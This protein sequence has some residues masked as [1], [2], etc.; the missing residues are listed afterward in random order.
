MTS[1]LKKSFLAFAHR[2]FF[3]RMSDE[4][5]LKLKYWA[6]LGKKLNLDAPCT[7]NEKLQW[8]KLYDRKPEYTTM[9]DKYAAKAYAGGRIG[10]E[11]VIPTLGIWDSFD[12]IDFD[13]LPDRFV[14]K[15]THDSG[16]VM[17]CEDK[18]TLDF[19]AARRK[20]N[21]CL[22]RNYYLK[23]REWPY[24]DVKPR[25]LA[26]QYMVDEATGE[27]RDYKFFC[28]H[29]QVK[30]FKVDFDRN[31]SHRAN[32]Y[33]P[34]GNL[35][36]FGETVCPPDYAKEIELPGTLR[37]MEEYAGR[38]SANCPFLR[39]DFYDV[40]GRIYFGE[41]TFYPNSGFGSF[42]DD[43]WDDRMGAWLSL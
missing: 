38:L 34:E 6:K 22:K 10:E 4:S 32:Y 9:V 31:V 30:C 13:S 37:Q 28:F 26:E 39:V 27:L 1:L 25:I 23:S 41:F 15:C 5:F 20:L 19:K 35:L 29:G 36:D 2:G 11:H 17:I 33:D 3:N 7:F 24:K 42:T 18:K 21:K 8:L 12:E 16:G 43:R 14:L 40:N